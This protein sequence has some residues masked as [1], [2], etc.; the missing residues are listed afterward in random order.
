MIW[1]YIELLIGY[2]I[3]FIVF[4]FMVLV[5]VPLIQIVEELWGVFGDED[6]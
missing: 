6:E 2:V 4:I 3:S 1:N 5:L